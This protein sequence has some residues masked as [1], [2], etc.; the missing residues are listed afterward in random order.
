MSLRVRAGRGG[1][2]PAR[3]RLC[4][5]ARRS[6][7]SR[8]V[9]ARLKPW[10]ENAR[11]PQGRPERQVRP[12][13]FANHG[14]AGAR[15]RAR[16]AARVLRAR[17]AQARTTWTASRSATRLDRARPTTTSPAR[18]PRRSRS[19][20]SRSTRATEYAARGRRLTLAL[21][22]RALS[23]ASRPT[24]SC[25]FVYEQDRDA[26]P[27][28]ARAHRAQRRADRPARSSRRRATSSASE[29]LQLEQEAT[30]S[31]ASRSTSARPSR[32]ARS[33][34]SKLK[35]PV[36][37]EDAERRAVDRRGVLAGAGARLSA[38][39]A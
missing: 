3:A 5:R 29:M 13:V 21:H 1:L 17:S 18:A 31:P 19:P 24:R 8:R 16:H 33:C 30:S 28:G 32:S 23:A 2:H 25:A 12:H 39:A 34:S 7:R 37:E 35:L 4:R 27:A 9:L 15:L 20:R 26:G 22:Q 10:L 6:C 11:Q 14:I 38:A 36:E